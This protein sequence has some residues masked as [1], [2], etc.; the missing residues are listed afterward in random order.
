MEMLIYLTACAVVCFCFIVAKRFLS[1]SG[2]DYGKKLPGPKS[3]P[4]VGNALSVDFRHLHISLYDYADKFGAIFQLKLFGETVIAINDSKL[5]RKALGSDVYG[6]DL[7]HRPATFFGK[8]LCFDSSDI[9]FGNANKTT[10]TMRKMFHKGLKLY[11]DGV[12]HFDRNTEAEI[13]RLLEELESMKEQDFDIYEVFRRSVANTTSSLMT[14]KA[15]EEDDHKLIW[16]FADA[17]RVVV[18][19]GMAFLYDLMPVLRHFPGP[20]GTMFRRAIEARD[21]FLHRFYTRFNMP[22]SNLEGTR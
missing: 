6:N 15:P 14:G 20:F 19:P 17:G 3:W 4:V 22:S 18:E 13:K 11:G 9:G 8:Y 16:Q 10:M 5:L 12:D 2:A 7:N 21:T 1:G